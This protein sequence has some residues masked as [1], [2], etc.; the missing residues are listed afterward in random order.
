[1]IS[2]DKS[3]MRFLYSRIQYEKGLDLADVEIYL[4]H[5][6]DEIVDSNI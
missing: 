4:G 3:R 2:S 6:H 1:M 5:V